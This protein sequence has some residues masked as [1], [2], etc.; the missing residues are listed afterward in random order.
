VSARITGRPRLNVSSQ[1]V[2]LADPQINVAGV[3]LPDF[4]AQA[5]LRAVL[6]PIPIGGLPLGLTLI[7]IDS[8]DD[9]CTPRWSGTTCRLP[10]N[11][12]PRPGRCATGPV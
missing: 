7:G 3:V 4:T 2:T 6:K 10:A 1:T 11:A 12:Q 8:R 9:G 5:L